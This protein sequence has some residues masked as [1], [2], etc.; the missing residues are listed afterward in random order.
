MARVRS[1][2]NLGEGQHKGRDR[3]LNQRNLHP[4]PL[5]Y[6]RKRSGAGES[7]EHLS[8]GIE[9]AEPSSSKPSQIYRDE[10]SGLIL[11]NTVLRSSNQRRQEILACTHLDDKVLAKLERMGVDGKQEQKRGKEAGKETCMEQAHGIGSNNEPPTPSCEEPPDP[12]SD[13]PKGSGEAMGTI[14]VEQSRIP[15]LGQPQTEHTQWNV[16]ASKQSDA[17]SLQQADLN[18]L[19]QVGSLVGSANR[20]PVAAHQA[21]V[22][23]DQQMQTV[24]DVN[25][26][27][28]MH[29]G[30]MC[31]RF[32]RPQLTPIQVASLCGAMGLTPPQLALQQ[33]QRPVVSGRS[34]G[35]NQ[36]KHNQGEVLNPAAVISE[37]F[38]GGNYQHGNVV[39][40]TY[41]NNP[42]AVSHNTGGT[43]GMLT[44]GDTT[45]QTD[46]SLF[47]PAPH[48][49]VVQQSSPSWSF[50]SQGPGLHGQKPSIDSHSDAVSRDQE[51]VLAGD[52]DGLTKNLE[53]A[54]NCVGRK[55]DRS[56]VNQSNRGGPSGR[57]SQRGDG[58]VSGGHHRKRHPHTEESRGFGVRTQSSSYEHRGGRSD[59]IQ[60]R[61]H[62]NVYQGDGS[63]PG[64]VQ[65]AYGPMMYLGATPPWGQP[66]P[67]PP[68]GTAENQV[69]Q[70]Q[71]TEDIMYQ[72][73]TSLNPHAEGYFIQPTVG[74]PPVVTGAPVTALG[75][76]QAMPSSAVAGI[77]GQMQSTRRENQG[78]SRGHRPQW[79]PIGETRHAKPLSVSTQDGALVE[80]DP[81]VYQAVEA[82]L[83][84]TGMPSD[85]T[86]RVN[87]P[88]DP[89]LQ[90]QLYRDDHHRNPPADMQSPRSAQSKSTDGGSGVSNASQRNSVRKQPDVTQVQRSAASDTHSLQNPPVIFG[91]VAPSSIDKLTYLANGSQGGKGSTSVNVGFDPINQMSLHGSSSRSNSNLH[92]P[93]TN[94]FGGR[95]MQVY[96]TGG[97]IPSGSHFLDRQKSNGAPGP[98][99]GVVNGGDPPGSRA[100][101]DGDPQ[102]IPEADHGDDGCWSSISAGSDRAEEARPQMHANSRRYPSRYSHRSG[103]SKNYQHDYSSRPPRY[104]RYVVK[105]PA[106]HISFMF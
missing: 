47:A 24:V 3:N 92:T 81:L 14:P 80:I 100:T 77:P 86:S 50:V 90:Q 1:A 22:L 53:V 26:T 61:Q 97:F 93:D 51:D 70:M 96:G 94:F 75:M 25:P 73:H 79:R 82:A 37:L 16:M 85:S 13:S 99:V 78:N 56:K 63:S 49:P 106:G 102:S 42:S 60:E 83:A 91:G 2:P 31:P 66:P 39:P 74:T 55:Q 89:D 98:A 11:P 32:Y 41:L 62:S 17:A 46:C 87:G 57:G 67:P 45:V 104:Y 43:T 5:P 64:P 30:Y 103:G 6:S 21:Q 71:S 12:A 69:I 28:D 8:A 40:V 15:D 9:R 101:P 72:L 7:N 33:A 27:I 84:G 38:S 105:L 18:S 88:P 59:R 35:I 65:S 58:S 20:R 4:Y 34:A 36:V 44:I 10:K 23:S 48:C 95:S 54:R 19:L 29:A 68:T 52:L 76:L